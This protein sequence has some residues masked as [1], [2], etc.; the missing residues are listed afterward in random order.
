MWYGLSSI[1]ARFLN[2]LLTP[3]LVGI[4][5]TA[6][7]GEM[8]LVYACIPFLNVVF[9]YG[10]ETTYFRFSN[11]GEDN[12]KV[13]STGSLSLLFSTLVLTAVLLI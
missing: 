13:F 8:S 9:T 5:A 12:R 2:Y 6:S 11:K 3:Y 4:L 7:Y 10:M 1:L